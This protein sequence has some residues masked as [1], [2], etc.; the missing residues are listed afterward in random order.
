MTPVATVP[1]SGST[2]RVA[3]HTVAPYYEVQALGSGNQVLGISPAVARPPKLMVFGKT[4]FVP[5]V[6]RAMGALPV[7]CYT[8]NPCAV[9][10]TITSGR[11][12]IAKTGSELVG[13]IG[14]SLAYF[15]LTAQGTR[16][17]TRARKLHVQ[18]SVHDADSGQTTTLPLT[19]VAFFASGRTATRQIS[20]TGA[21]RV[22][23]LTDFVS[24]DWVG[25]ILAGCTGVPVCQ[26]ATTLSV[27]STVIARTA[28]QQIG[29]GELSYLLFTLTPKGHAMLARAKG[30]RLT[31]HATLSGTT[32]TAVANV[33]LVGY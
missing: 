25:G 29:Q 5:G 23:G 3:I 17:L 20:H 28:S 21:I 15:R 10:T 1:V 7:G 26:T 18:V 27:G 12:V 4:A 6:P 24:S 14:T 11:T 16:L 30:N 22:V 13:A 31:V 19:L 32:G 9:S 2:T 33:A 8:G